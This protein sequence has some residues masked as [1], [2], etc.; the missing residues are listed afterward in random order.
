MVRH[1]RLEFRCEALLFDLD[2]VLVDS[3]AVVE[4]TWQRWAELHQLDP[5]LLLRVAHGRR[6]R[7]TLQAVVPHLNTDSEAAWLDTAQLADSQ[8]LLAVE[9]ALGLVSSLPTTAWAVVTSGG[10]ALARRRLESA[11]LPVPGVLVASEDVAQGKPAPE[12]YQLAAARLGREPGSCLVFEDA[13]PGLAAGRAAGARVV[14]LTTTHS[15][16]QLADADAIIP[17]LARID[18]LSGSAG[19]IVKI[20]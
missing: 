10:H 2:G 16:D 11:G 15:A 12:G 3:R 18:L 17:N 13:P 9:G 1:K 8:G 14:A 5:R 4:R 20:L 19:F 7:E 6:T